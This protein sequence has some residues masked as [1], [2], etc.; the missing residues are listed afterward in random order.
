MRK[1]RDRDAA[2]TLRIG[3]E[4][5]LWGASPRARLDRRCVGV[6]AQS[7]LDHRPAARF[8]WLP[9]L[10]SRPIGGAATPGWCC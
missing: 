2:L 1:R 4:G 9:L 10:N 8:G 3:G 7:S 6:T 5:R